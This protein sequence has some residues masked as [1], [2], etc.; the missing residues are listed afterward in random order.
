[1]RLREGV[2]AHGG[3]VQQFVKVADG[4]GGGGGGSGGGIVADDRFLRDNGNRSSSDKDR[5]D[6][7]RAPC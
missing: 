5:S 7:P 1:M 6:R 2:P 3:R 4:G